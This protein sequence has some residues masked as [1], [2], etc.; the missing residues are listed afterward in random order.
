MQVLMRICCITSSLLLLLAPLE[1]LVAQQG[2]QLE[3]V[4][5]T[6]QKREQGLSEV[7]ISM[8][9]I[10]EQF[11]DARN[12]T[13]IADLVQYAP[14]V[15]ITEQVLG[16]SVVSI[17]GF[18][19]GANRGFEQSVGRYVDGIF[20][21]RTAS[22][23][24]DLNDIQRVEILRG[25]QGTLFGNN[26][27][28]GTLNIITK[29]TNTD[30]FEGDIKLTAGSDNYQSINGSITGPIT[31]TL[32]YR[33][34]LGHRSQDGFLENL[35]DSLG[36]ADKNMGD[37]N[38]DV[39][40]VKL[41]W[42]PNDMLSVKLATSGENAQS[43]MG[44]GSE[45]FL[46]RADSEIAIALG[47]LSVAAIP[48]YEALIPA[49]EFKIDDGKVA[50]DAGTDFKLDSKLHNLI[51]DYDF[52]N[53]QFK[54]LTAYGSY[55][56]TQLFDADFSPVNLLVRT[57]S[58]SYRQFSQELQWLS[59][60]SD[61]FTSV[62]GL[63]W[64][65][66]ELNID[67]EL[68]ADFNGVGL[69]V[70][71]L[72]IKYFEQDYQSAAV[73]GQGTWLMASSWSLTAGMRYSSEKKQA[74]IKHNYADCVFFSPVVPEAC[75]ASLGTGETYALD[76]EI[77]DSNISLMLSV[78]Y[79]INDE[80]NSYL[81]VAEGYKSGG[82]SAEDFYI[83]NNNNEFS[84]EDATTYEAGIKG[85]FLDGA[86]WLSAAIFY[87][88]F[89]NMQVSIFNGT[90]FTVSNAAESTSQGLEID[91]QW[92]WS[93]AL[94][95]TGSLGYIDATYGAYADGPCSVDQLDTVG[96]NCT[97]D[98]SG[99]TLARAP[100]W[101][102]S[103]SIIYNRPLFDEFELTLNLDLIYSDSYFTDIDLDTNTY[104]DAYTMVNAR[105]ALGPSVG[106]WQVGLRGTNLSDE[107]VITGHA[108]VPFTRGSYGARI[109]PP[110]SYF[111]D[112]KVSF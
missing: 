88:E 47:P 105:I 54:S 108:D 107:T 82:F 109:L 91:A 85:A 1:L 73:Y 78:G 3:E 97:Q 62:L 35:A 52:G 16:F 28:A 56:D 68:A 80:W 19:G 81:R 13:S 37:V 14:N 67:S 70:S 34:S 25:P 103:G 39:W 43:N 87:T 4:I 76:S 66:T 18:A 100:D 60:V 94:T 50:H 61:N 7:P 10:N 15:T 22:N 51:V 106:G 57:S 11:I 74:I 63:F 49:I 75:G 44:Y 5:V 29:P 31:D 111:L 48:V 64:L 27:I 32:S 71:A 69:P 38:K 55:D 12:L 33:I 83:G 101:N 89:D 72:D 95:L 24:S 45:S 23:S 40:R 30:F 20:S 9:V 2:N 92:L 36:N 17:R 65:D 98:L 86:A 46:G 104:Q 8:S 99:E 90:G 26:T 93:E 79:E 110:R 59:Q 84:A 41:N 77:E 58:E 21:G 112:L 42:Q 6:A 96:A 53:H 102:A